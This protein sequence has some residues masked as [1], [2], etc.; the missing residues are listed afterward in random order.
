VNTD[1]PTKDRFED[2]LLA[3][4]LDDFDELRTTTTPTRRSPHRGSRPV[5][6][7]RR[8]VP[9]L[10][11]T[12]A[13]A[14]LGIAAVTAFGS[15][16][17]SAGP[18]ATRSAQTAPPVR[19]SRKAVRAPTARQS[20]LFRLASVS[21]AAP[22]PPGRYVVL[23][24]TDTQTGY[25]GESKR[26]TVIDTLT[27]AS[28]TYQAAFPSAGTPPSS[29]YTSEPSTLTEG[30]DPSSTER[31]YSALP[32]EPTALRAKLLALAKQQAAKT[33]RELRQQA[34][35][36]GK[37]MRLKKS[38]LR[39]P[40]LSDDDYVYQEADQLLWSPLV[41]PALRSA[42]YKVLAETSGFTITSHA[43]DPA[44]RPAIAMT[45]RYTGVR[46]TDTTYENPATGAVL[47]QS[48]KGGGGGTITAVYEPVSST[49]TIPSDPSTG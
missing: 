16:Q 27:G 34:K 6:P 19:L 32:T 48:W 18:H 4:V 41:E 13:A 20:V 7:I 43:T 12:A 5:R 35:E 30:P 23:P 47:A 31:W 22:A 11:A 29:A 14:T 10:V 25:P 42:L 1:S 46:E 24:E 45:R 37:E 39:Q 38:L 2:R 21:A 28:T 36:V 40:V 26:T 3:A 49:D 9:A 33:A 17:P 44:G 8:P 15:H